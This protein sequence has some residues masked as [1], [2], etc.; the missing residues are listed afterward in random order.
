MGLIHC[1]LKV[2]DTIAQEY[3]KSSA[4]LQGMPTRKKIFDTFYNPKAAYFV[5]TNDILAIVTVVSIAGLVLETVVAL[6]PYQ[7]VFTTIEYVTVAFFTLEYI[8]RIIAH[9]KNW[10]RYVFSFFGIIDLVAIVPSY[11]GF[12]NLTFLKAARVF[13]ILQLLRMLRLLKLS[14]RV[15]GTDETIHN[16]AVNRLTLQIYFAALFSATLLFA[17]LMYIFES[18]NPEFTN[19]PLAMLW[20][21]KPLL[22]GVAQTM[23]TTIAGDIIVAIVRFTG[24]ILFGLLISIVG[25]TTRALLIGKDD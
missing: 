25:N 5:I 7:P 2:I 16:K 12:A 21:I 23:P 15:T 22:G 24:L 1:T 11:L 13:R 9:G 8:T 18:D 3:K 14:R 4:I 6:S 10:K 19:I 20:T 17:S